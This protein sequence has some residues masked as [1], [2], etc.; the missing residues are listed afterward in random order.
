MWMSKE[1]KAQLASMRKNMDIVV[2][3]NK[4]TPSIINEIP[5]LIRPWMPGT[6]AIGD[7]RMYGGIP[8]RC[9]Q[10]HDSAANPGWNPAETPSLWMQ[11][12]GTTP[13]TARPWIAPAG[14]H[15]M[16]RVGEY[17]IYTDGV[18]YK[19]IADTA[20][21]PDVYAAAWEAANE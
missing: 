8:Y 6:Y 9:V 11:Y 14:S 2:D 16:Y 12:H 21:A 1:Q 18:M 5:D 17:M 15:D 3:A 4:E 20:Y 19:C 7:V 13:E 10:A